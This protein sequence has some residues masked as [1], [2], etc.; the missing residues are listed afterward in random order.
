M[1]WSERCPDPWLLGAL[2]ALRDLSTWRCWI[3]FDKALT[4][5]ALDATELE[6]LQARGFAGQLPRC[7]RH[8]ARNRAQVGAR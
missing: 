5:V 7:Y 3:A 4:G 2:P 6:V 1:A 8:E